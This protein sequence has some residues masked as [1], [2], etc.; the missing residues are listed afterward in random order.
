MDD[1]LT[2]LLHEAGLSLQGVLQPLS[3]GDSAATHRLQ[4]CDV[5]V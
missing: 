2:A 1:T 5:V 3:G 4:T